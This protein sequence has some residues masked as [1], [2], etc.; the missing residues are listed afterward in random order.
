MAS[1]E[2][3]AVDVASFVDYS[4][5]MTS[6]SARSDMQLLNSQPTPEFYRCSRPDLNRY[7][8]ILPYSHSR[9]VLLECNNAECADYIN[10]CHIKPF[11]SRDLTRY[12]AAGAPPV[13][14]YDNFWKLIWEQDVRVIVML[15]QEKENG[16]RKADPYWP[17]KQRVFGEVSVELLDCSTEGFVVTRAFNITCN[18]VTRSLTHFQ[19]TGWPDHGA[20]SESDALV[21]LFLRYRQVRDSLPRGSGPVVV[22]CSAGVGRSGTFIGA[23]MVLD[24]LTEPFPLDSLNLFSLIRALRMSRTQMV[25]SWEQYLYLHCFI[26]HCIQNRLFGVSS[27]IPQP[28]K[29]VAPPKSFDLAAIPSVRDLHSEHRDLH[30]E[31]ELMREELGQSKAALAGSQK[32]TELLSQVISQ[33]KE[34]YIAARVQLALQAS[35]GGA[36][37]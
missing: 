21:P 9:V 3:K 23:D 32:E 24:N 27:R 35:T 18:N 13:T 29:L 26:A 4:R 7:Q 2:Q 12:I 14:A 8:D 15:T 19:Y 28:A 36:S 6:Q 25:Q 34:R 33:L 22:H 10:A 5:A 31:L 1:A 17:K 11:F 20:P 16:R 37:L 30:R